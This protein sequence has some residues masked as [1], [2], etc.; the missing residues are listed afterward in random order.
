MSSEYDDIINL[1][2]H[3]SVRHPQMDLIKR[4]AQ[5]APFAAL[6]GYDDA[7]EETARLT[8]ERITLE[9][10]SLEELDRALAVIRNT[11][12]KERAAEITYY[13]PDERKEGGEYRTITA[14]VLR[15]DD[16]AREIVL[17]GKRRISMDRITALRFPAQGE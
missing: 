11:P 10:D 1:P 17:E 8:Q 5:F 13:V 6:T 3:V 15:I 2:H 12:A 9:E 7:I 14:A 16:T 4:A